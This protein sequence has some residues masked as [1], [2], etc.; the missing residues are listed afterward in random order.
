MNQINNA[1]EIFKFLNKSNCR[2]CNEAT[3][4]AF[5]AAVFKG[6]KRIGECPDLDPEIMARYN[7]RMKKPKTPEAQAGEAIAE[8]KNQLRNVD[9]AQAARRLDGRYRNGKLT[10][11]IPGKDFGVDTIGNF[12][13]NIH[14]HG[15]VALPVLT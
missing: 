2:K 13:T 1:M 9:L 14:V 4:L 5:A 15:W 3:C 10:L 7:G 11:K 6:T 12:F 8:L